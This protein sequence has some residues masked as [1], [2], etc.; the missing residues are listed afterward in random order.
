MTQHLFSSR[1]SYQRRA[2]L[3]ASREVGSYSYQRMNA[4]LTETETP[5][6]GIFADADAIARRKARRRA[7][8]LGGE[9]SRND[10]TDM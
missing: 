7:I 1:D 8:M 4:T 5:V 10:V 9:C 2:H 3:T 6:R